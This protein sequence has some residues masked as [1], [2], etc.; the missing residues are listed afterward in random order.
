M[1]CLPDASHTIKTAQQRPAR[2]RFF[3][4]TAPPKYAHRTYAFLTPKP[5]SK[6]SNRPHLPGKGRP[7]NW[8]L[9]KAIRD[10]ILYNYARCGSN[11]LHIRDLD[12]RDTCYTRTCRISRRPASPQ[13]TS[14]M[15]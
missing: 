3:L 9:R 15:V 2:A 6:T 13:N 12:T 10:G 7:T 8:I 1:Q 5:G 14:D 4:P 11:S